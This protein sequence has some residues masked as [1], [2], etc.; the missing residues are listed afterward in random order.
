VYVIYALAC[1]SVIPPITAFVVLCRWGLNVPY[2][3]DWDFVPVLRAAAEGHLGWQHFWAHHNE[4]RIVITRA[5]RLALAQLTQWDLRAELIANFVLSGIT[6]ALLIALLRR[7]LQSSAPAS[8]PYLITCSS[9]FAFPIAGWENWLF[10]S[11]IQNYL[12]NAAAV[13]VVFL[14]SRTGRTWAGVLL[15]TLATLVAV[16]CYGNGLALLPL[17]PVGLALA[18]DRRCGPSRMTAVVVAVGLGIAVVTAYFLH[19]ATTPTPFS[20]F[21]RPSAYG[22]Y[23]LALLGTPFWL[24]DA[25]TAMALGGLGLAVFVYVLWS[26]ARL[27]PEKG[28]ALLPWLLL[29]V[30][31]LLNGIVITLARVRYFPT[32]Q[33]LTP[34]YVN[35]V[36]FFWL[37]LFV[38]IVIA[39]TQATAHTR[40]QAAGSVVLAISVLMWGLSLAHGLPHI[41]REHSAITEGWRCLRASSSPPDACIRLVYYDVSQDI[42]QRIQ[43]VRETRLTLFAAPDSR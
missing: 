20:A 10:G 36:G 5:V 15:S 41:R 8:L 43:W 19:N 3:D 22:A 37:G 42:R 38:V 6:L 17:L 12:G 4:H 14:M 31:G 33:A 21:E 23:F 7:T 27:W 18:P 30:Y 40:R 29:A 24:W 1:A 9:A 25:Q 39:A 26:V 34:R 28:E 35:F 2:W 13:L 11:N 32:E 16:L